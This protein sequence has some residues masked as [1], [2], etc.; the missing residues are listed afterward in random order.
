MKKNKWL[1]M[2]LAA[3]LTFGV[4]ACGGDD[5]SG[6]AEPV[7]DPVPVTEE[8]TDDVTEEVTDDVTEEVTDDVMEDVDFVGDWDCVGYDADGQEMTEEECGESHLT[9]HNNYTVDAEIMDINYDGE[10]DFTESGV[11]LYL[12]DGGYEEEVYCD[13]VDNVMYMDYMN[14]YT[15]FMKAE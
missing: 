6:T 8:V 15:L 14:M 4:T 1:A 5:N 11:V 13:M 10:W 7:T 9:L 3:M 2:L 12:Y